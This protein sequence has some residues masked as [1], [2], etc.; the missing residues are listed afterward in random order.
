MELSCSDVIA[1]LIYIL[2]IYELFDNFIFLGRFFVTSGSGGVTGGVSGLTK[3]QKQALAAVT[4]YMRL[5]VPS[6][7]YLVSCV[8]KVSDDKPTVMSQSN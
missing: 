8:Y 6:P 3:P 2:Y 5:P 1:Q 4:K 7:R